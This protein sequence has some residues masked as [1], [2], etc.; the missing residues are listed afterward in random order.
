ML[1]LEA[2]SALTADEPF[3]GQT[4]TT[5]PANGMTSVH[6]LAGCGGD[7][8]G[9]VQAGFIPVAAVNHSTF[10][11][12]IHEA[13]F[14]GEHHKVG[15]S[16]ALM[17]RMPGAHA[18]WMSLSCTRFCPGGKTGQTKVAY[19]KRR[20]GANN[21]LISGQHVLPGLHVSQGQA[22]Q[23]AETRATAA[24]MLEYVRTH[25]ELQVLFSENVIE[26]ATDWEDF[27]RWIRDMADLGMI[28]YTTSVTAAHLA[29]EGNPAPAQYRDRFIA[30]FVRKGAPA[31]D[32][33]P[34]PLSWCSNCRTDV[35]GV[36]VFK[37]H[38]HMRIGK[39]GSRNGQYYY[40][41]PKTACG[42]S[43]VQP[44]VTPASDVLDLDNRGQ[45]IAGRYCP[46]TRER[47]AIGLQRYPGARHLILPY[48]KNSHVRGV[49]V[50][51]GA[52][53]TKD[54]YALVTVDLA[55]P[56]VDTCHLRM[57]TL[58]EIQDFQRFPAS[59][60]TPPGMAEKEI[61]K[62]FGNAVPP[63]MAAWVAHRYL[64]TL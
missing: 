63:N 9:L 35:H 39:Y 56:T 13:N 59:F 45:L 27:G 28:G 40:H 52:L 5:R 37:K 24:D 44:H 54:R 8:L 19:D 38:N 62:C 22:S 3:Y 15:T 20:A 46:A 26:F 34:R 1:K 47:L 23:W 64:D 11:I 41:C 18:G 31:P 57:V 58:Q 10:A 2:R 51:I 6:F 12:D 50:P 14:T 25:P 36:R 61:K 53:T 60:R 21:S 29:E 55:N 43:P 32:L 33:E 4:I 16:P 48:Y 7:T 30:V 49:D 17:R 42:N